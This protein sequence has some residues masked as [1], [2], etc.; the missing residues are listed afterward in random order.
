MMQFRVVM[1][2]IRYNIMFAAHLD[3]DRCTSIS[4][5]SLVLNANTAD[6][7]TQLLSLTSIYV[8]HQP[9]FMFILSDNVAIVK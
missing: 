6:L 7:K 5:Q 1:L 9:L 4:Q 3:G 2:F 8:H